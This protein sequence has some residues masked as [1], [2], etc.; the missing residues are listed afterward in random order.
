[1]TDGGAAGA[2]APPEQRLALD[3]VVE[4]IKAGDYDAA[5]AACEAAVQRFPQS[6]DALHLTG[7]LHQLKGEHEQ[8][9]VWFARAAIKDPGNAE[10]LNNYA[11]SLKT[12]QR[13]GEAEDLY[14]QAIRVDP[15]NAPA[16]YNLAELLLLVER[17]AEALAR[18]RSALEILPGLAGAHRLAGF[19]LQAQGRR[20]EA[21]QAFRASAANGAERPQAQICEALAL[22]HHGDFSP[23]WDLYEARLHDPDLRCLHEHF[24][25]PRWRGASL[26]QRSLLVCREQGIGDE[27][28][29]AT[30]LPELLQVAGRC[31]VTCERRLQAL[32]ERSFPTVVFL[33][34]SEAEIRA[35]L[36]GERIDYQIPAGSLPLVFRT[37]AADFPSRDAILRADPVR[38]DYWRARLAALGPGPKLG[39]TWRAG[40]MRTG[41]QRR[42]MPLEL[43]APILDL[44]GAH[45]ISLQ[46]D[47]QAASDIATVGA[48]IEHWPEVL[49]SYDDTAALVTALD[50]TASVC[51]SIVH[52]CGALGSPVW[53]MVPWLAEW[54][55][56]DS[57]ETMPW[58]RSPRLFRQLAYGDWPPV[59]ARLRRELQARFPA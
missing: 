8:A 47:A 32:F 22:L 46:H 3:A 18:S 2:E 11:S 34:G 4:Q 40:G 28:M 29:F 53:V 23:G 12:L 56:G 24:D 59:V 27:I 31:F 26:A 52:L 15:E 45:W 33:S 7:Y 44:P 37:Q 25:Y 48:R 43:L 9:I 38:V 41:G 6:A 51:G 58:Y 19:A 17:P 21:I 42:S 50:L 57:G 20:E 55:Y 54:R 39:L 13:F 35:R 49:A 10:I 5:L 16:H 36:A 1:M 30:C 14:R